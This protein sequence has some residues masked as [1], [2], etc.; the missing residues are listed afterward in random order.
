M[1]SRGTGLVPNQRVTVSSGATLLIQGPINFRLGGEN[2][3]FIR[4]RLDW[5]QFPEFALCLE[6]YR[7]VRIRFRP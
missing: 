2:G 3:T 4:S 5:T 7:Y 1:L 6:Q